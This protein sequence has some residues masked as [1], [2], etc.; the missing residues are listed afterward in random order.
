LLYW[1]FKTLLVRP[2]LV[3]LTRPWLEGEENIPTTGPA[4]LVSNHLSAG[5]T[6]LLPALIKRRLTFPAKA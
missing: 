5:D 3:L 4:I 1:L 6:F 2:G